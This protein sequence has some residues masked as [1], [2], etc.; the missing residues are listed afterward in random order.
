MNTDDRTP[1]YPAPPVHAEHY[2]EHPGCNTWGGFG[3]AASKSSVMRWWCWPHYPYK[4]PGSVR[5][6][7]SLPS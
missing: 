4:E 6:G 2:C 3:L 5:T 1:T 7:G